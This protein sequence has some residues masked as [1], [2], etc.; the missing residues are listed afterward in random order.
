MARTYYYFRERCAN[1]IF[2]HPF[3][4][5]KMMLLQNFKGIQTKLGIAKGY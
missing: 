2:F 4:K 3:Q 5:P 1:I